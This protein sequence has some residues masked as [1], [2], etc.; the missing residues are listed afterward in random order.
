MGVC[1]FKSKKAHAPIFYELLPNKS[2][3]DHPFYWIHNVL[4]CRCGELGIFKHQ[5]SSWMSISVDNSLIWPDKECLVVPL[6][7]NIYVLGSLIS[8]VFISLVFSCFPISTHMCSKIVIWKSKIKK[9]WPL[10]YT[11]CLPRGL[12]V[13]IDNPQDFWQQI[14]RS[15][16]VTCLCFT[17][18]WTFQ[19]LTGFDQLWTSVYCT[20][21]IVFYTRSLEVKK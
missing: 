21:K 17:F 5:H 6:S 1:G 20:L 15:R 14:P 11:N 2:L 10:L 16:R 7:C 3:D 8:G 13:R 9:M 18:G 12:F 19:F 4:V